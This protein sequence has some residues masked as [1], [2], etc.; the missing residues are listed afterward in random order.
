MHGPLLLFVLSLWLRAASGDVNTLRCSTVQTPEWTRTLCFE[1][2]H[3]VAY[4][5][6]EGHANITLS[7]DLFSDEASKTPACGD[8]LRVQFVSAKALVA[9]TGAIAV[10]RAQPC[11][12]YSVLLRFPRLGRCAG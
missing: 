4:A 11:G 9:P 3:D 1:P 7:W 12:H 8:T 2:E 5:P 6:N 10:E